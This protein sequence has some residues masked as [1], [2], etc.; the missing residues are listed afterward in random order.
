MNNNTR[1]L[2]VQRSKKHQNGYIIVKKCKE[3]K[4]RKTYEKFCYYVGKITCL[5][6]IHDNCPLLFLYQV[7]KFPISK[8]PSNQRDVLLKLKIKETGEEIDRVAFYWN[9]QWLFPS[10]ENT[11]IINSKTFDLKNTQLI[12]WKEILE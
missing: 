2:I 9:K 8:T 10:N 5:D 6:D 12:S 7:E 4:L 11:K 3:C 1:V